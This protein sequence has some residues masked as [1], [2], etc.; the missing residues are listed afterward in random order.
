MAKR[1]TKIKIYGENQKLK[2]IKTVGKALFFI[3][4]SFIL[5]VLFVFFYYAKDLPRPEKFI[6]KEFIEST[7]IYDRT[8]Q[9]LL[10]NIY[11]EE[12]R[13]VVSM[14]KIPN[15]LIQA[16]LAAEDRN[17]Y[18]HHGIDLRGV[19]RSILVNLKLRK[20]A[21]GGS[22]ITQQ[23]IR[24]SFLTLSKT[25]ERKIREIILAIELERRYSKEQILEWYLNQVPFGSN[26]YGVE[27]ASQTYFKK[28]VQD[29]TLEE[30]AILASLICGPS[31]LSPYGQN[32]DD[33]LVRK[34]Y[35]LD[36]MAE[37]NY[38]SKEQAEET[39][40]KEI[41]FVPKIIEIKAPHFTLYIKEQLEREYGSDFLKENGLKIY[42]SLDWDLQQAAE[43][44]VE[45]RMPAN[46]ANKAYNASLVA[47]DPKT[48]QVLAMV[49][50]KDY[51]GQSYPEDCIPGKNCLFEPKVNVAVYG[52]GRQPGSAFKPFAYVTAF[53]KGYNDKTTVV[54]EQTNFGIWGG[55][56]YIPQNYDGRFRG[57]ITLRNALAQSINVA[58]VKVLMNLAGLDDTITTAQKLGI[59]TLNPPFGPSIV[60][61]GWEVKLLEMTSAY[62][63][64][65]T[66]GLKVPPVTILKIEDAKGNIIK[67][68]KKTPQR[69]LGIRE[70]EILNSI[71]SDN[72]ARAPMFGSNSY[73]YIPEYEPAVKTGT[74]QEYR[75]AWCI[76][77]TPSLVCGVWAGNN[78]NSPTNRKPGVTL[79]GPIWKNFMLEAFKKYPKENFTHDLDYQVESNQF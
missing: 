16:I 41:N 2:K 60:L 20:P 70:T 29:L 51:F 76:G 58:S 42:T 14:D 7:K 25:P 57:I 24:S 65:A 45:D 28:S 68:D 1:I 32:K 59:S 21:V 67:E 55:Q 15:H 23:L 37:L 19:A 13:T 11:G 74:T 43:K 72:Q 40:K 12:K 17:F 31:R 38:I 5:L 54:D 33:L 3:L 22:T 18:T 48:G 50:S 64:F 73:L 63:V 52:I 30:A 10:Y 66:N 47:L 36:E 39:K 62:G 75:N 4:L 46:E 8:G 56:A 49:G 69:V 27:A 34:N 26:A 44:S 71:L 9:V 79:A 35:V 77:Y 53:Q 61:G 78:D 6:E